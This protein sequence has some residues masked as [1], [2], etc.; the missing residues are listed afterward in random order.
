MEAP[1]L[2]DLT[3]DGTLDTTNQHTQSSAVFQMTPAHQPM[4]R[5][6]LMPNMFDYKKKTTADEPKVV[7]ETRT[8]ADATK[9][10]HAN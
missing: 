9:R 3:V 1:S 5:N 4:R 6:Y 10:T 8:P 7:F 2:N